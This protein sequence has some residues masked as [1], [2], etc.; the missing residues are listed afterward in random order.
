[1]TEIIFNK[2]F[3]DLARDRAADVLQAWQW[4]LPVWLQR[5]FVNY[6]ADH[7]EASAYITVDKDYRFANIWVC[8]HWL[9]NTPEEQSKDLLHEII[10][11]YNVPQMDF[12]NYL[13]EEAYKGD[14]QEA[15]LKLAKK[16]L[17][18]KN[19]AS[20]ADLTLAIANKFV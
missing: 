4:L 19:E 12:A 10:H 6:H 2:N 5:L 9:T 14:G 11:L 16:E 3:P 18:A 8:G 13:I 20:T 1:M 15:L 7:N 17:T